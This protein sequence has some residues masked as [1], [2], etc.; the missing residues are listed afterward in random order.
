MWSFVRSIS[1]CYTPDY[2]INNLPYLQTFS[3]FFVVQFNMCIMNFFFNVL[4]FF[5]INIA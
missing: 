3:V 4:F 5:S 2:L 1:R